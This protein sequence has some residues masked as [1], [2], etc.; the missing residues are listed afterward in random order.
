MS[1]DLRLRKLELRLDHVAASKKARTMCILCD[2]AMP[3]DAE[4]EA[5]ID[6]Y[7][8]RHPDWDTEDLI[9]IRVNNRDIIDEHSQ[10]A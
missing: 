8:A 7:K 2:T 4:T 6:D 5:A 9:K 10:Q 3:T 1:F